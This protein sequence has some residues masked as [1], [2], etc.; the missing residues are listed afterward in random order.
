LDII[1]AQAPNL[2]N[3]ILWC[4]RRTLGQFQWP[5]IKFE[6]RSVADFGHGNRKS[7]SAVIVKIIKTTNGLTTTETR[8]K[9]CAY[10]EYL[11]FYTFLMHV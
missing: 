1:S 11:E 10:L 7:K 4:R 2:L 6:I 3:K 9:I 5:I 8:Q